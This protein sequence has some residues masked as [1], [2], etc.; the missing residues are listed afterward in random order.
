MC[1][2]SLLTEKLTKQYI[3]DRQITENSFMCKIKYFWN[4]VSNTMNT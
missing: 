2:E 3:D 4:V 1:V